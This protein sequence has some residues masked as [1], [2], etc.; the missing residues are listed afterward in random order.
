[1][2]RYIFLVYVNLGTPTDTDGVRVSEY[3][4]KT[5]LSRPTI[6]DLA[7]FNPTL[8][9]QTNALRLLESNR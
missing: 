4:P 5:G 7:T 9:I 3:E 6:P 2:T 1:M 8:G